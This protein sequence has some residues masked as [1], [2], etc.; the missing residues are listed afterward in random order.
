MK[1]KIELKQEIL[2]PTSIHFCDIPHFLGSVKKAS[3]RTCKSKA[4]VDGFPAMG[5]QMLNDPDTQEF[6]QEVLNI[7]HNVLTGSGYAMS[8]F[9]TQMNAMWTQEHGYLSSMEQ[10]VHGSG[11]QLV[12]FYFLDSPKNCGRAI[13]HDP[14]PGKVQVNLPEQNVSMATIASQMINFEMIPGRLILAPSWLPH[15]LSKNQNKKPAK[16][17]HFNIGVRYSPSITCCSP[18]AEVV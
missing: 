17:V 6:Q 10:H 18:A 2:F 13:F 5:D 11:D 15:S 3:K 16:L 7:A 4:I 8:E 1:N 14:R 9:A 12:G